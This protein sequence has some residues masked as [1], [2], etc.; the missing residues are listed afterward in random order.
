M[1][2]AIQLDEND[3]VATALCDIRA[4]SYTVILNKD[5]CF[6]L[7]VHSD[8]P[9]GHKISLSFV[10]KGK[11]IIKYGHIIGRAL[12]DIKAGDYIHIHNIESLR[13]R[14]DL[15]TSQTL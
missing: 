13:G 3:N 12:D 11:M 9:A 7:L 15:D 8:I 1:Y 10:R 5:S 14:G 2:N 6:S 4:N